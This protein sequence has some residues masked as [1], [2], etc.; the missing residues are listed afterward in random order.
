LLPTIKDGSQWVLTHW[1]PSEFMPFFEHRCRTE[2]RGTGHWSLYVRSRWQ[3]PSETTQFHCFIW[4]LS[5]ITAGVAT[6]SVKSLQFIW[7]QRI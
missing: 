6:T 3:N 2:I 1:E 4:G 5:Q 7:N